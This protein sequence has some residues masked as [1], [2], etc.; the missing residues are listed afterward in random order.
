MKNIHYIVKIIIVLVFIKVII[1]G[2]DFNFYL[3]YKFGK[4][5][6]NWYNSRE[7]YTE[8][9][10]RKQKEELKNENCK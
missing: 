7:T 1:I 3:W 10:V 5:Y 9:K 2:S 8:F 6:S 4:D